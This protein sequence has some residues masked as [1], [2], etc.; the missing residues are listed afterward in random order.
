MAEQNPNK[1]NKFESRKDF[2]INRINKAFSNNKHLSTRTV[3]GSTGLL[4][5]FGEYK[6]PNGKEVTLVFIGDAEL[7]QETLKQIDDLISK[8]ISSK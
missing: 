2:I 4:T 1:P 8:E 6:V 5:L 3:F 7:S